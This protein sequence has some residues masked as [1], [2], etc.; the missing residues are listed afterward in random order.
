MKKCK[1]HSFSEKKKKPD[2]QKVEYF[3]SM[4]TLESGEPIQSWKT[5]LARIMED[6]AIRICHSIPEHSIL[7]QVKNS[8]CY[9]TEHRKVCL[10]SMI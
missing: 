3:D 6:T 1:R 7:T 8:I 5:V 9:K 10:G 4:D 2:K